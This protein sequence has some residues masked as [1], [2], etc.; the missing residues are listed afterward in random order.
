VLAEFGDDATCYAD[1]TARK[2]YAGTSTITRAFGTRRV[3]L[4]RYAP[5]S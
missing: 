5:D 4:A 1:A 3:V 2:N